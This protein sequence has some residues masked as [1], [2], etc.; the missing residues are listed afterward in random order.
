MRQFQTSAKVRRQPVQKAASS[1]ALDLGDPPDFL[2]AR[3]EDFAS[4]PPSDVLNFSSA[5]QSEP[6][7]FLNL[8]ILEDLQVWDELGP[9]SDFAGLGCQDNTPSPSMMR[10]TDNISQ[11][12]GGWK[13]GNMNSFPWFG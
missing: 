8:D 11:L 1:S 3:R 7:R 4:I 10:F 12:A 2:D 6:N 9:M 13:L 5:E